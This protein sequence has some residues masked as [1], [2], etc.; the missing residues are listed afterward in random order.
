MVKKL[1]KKDKD[2]I[3]YDTD[4]IAKN[5]WLSLLRDF[6]TEEGPNFAKSAELA[7]MSGV[8]NFRD[9]E[10]PTIGLIT[11]ARFKRYKQLE[12][13]FK[14]YRFADD[15]YSDEELEFKTYQSFFDAQEHLAA[16]HP[17]SEIS[18]RVL[19]RARSIA[20][21]I[22]G[23]YDPEYTLTACRF[24]KKS[25]I[26][27]PLS[28]AY[29]DHKLT[30]AEAFTGSSECSRWFFESLLPGD[31]I[32]QEL[33][34]A[35]GVEPGS[36]ASLQHESLTLI[37]VP[38]SWKTY[39]PITPLTLLSLLYSYGVGE[40]VTARLRSIGLD[41][42]TLQHRHAK[43]VVKFSQTLSHATADLSN[44]SN[45]LLSWMLNRVL[46]REWYVAVKRTFQHQLAVKK[47]GC[48]ESVLHYTESVLPMGNGLTF[49]VET[50]VFYILLKA[51]AELSEVKGLISVYGDDLI[52]PSRLH[53]YVVAIF[54]QLKLT[55]NLEKTFVH[56]P[57]RESC[58]SDYYRGVDVR[59]AILP[60]KHQLLTRTCYSVWL[61]KV[62][63][64][65][66]R[67]WDPTEIESTLTLLLTELAS[68][69]LPL[70]RVP[71]SYPD[72]AGV[73]V[74]DPWVIPMD[75]RVLPWKPISIVFSNGSRAH[76]FY[77]LQVSST[78]RRVVS[79]LP[80]Y[81]LALQGLDDEPEPDNFWQTDFTYLRETPRKPLIWRT[82]K[83][84]R[85]TVTSNGKRK[86]V[87][88]KQQFAE[89]TSRRGIRLAPVL[90]GKTDLISDWI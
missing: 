29:I 40:Q 77:S 85:W 44:A 4:V 65:L 31:P 86:R 66:V 59:P 8:A 72:T 55:L 15:K 1:K 67:R 9:Y 57:F 45:S 43:L 5:I 18:H 78:T 30:D 25:S 80:Y 47:P 32:L 69:N 51:I 42:A 23:P 36:T 35:L 20:R 28:L 48:D 24:G 71:P 88:L 62:Y 13:F 81:W 2:V 27:C 64:L 34:S 14:K 74:E 68:L 21:S 16:Y 89:C 26:G 90:S 60:D 12:A 73:K 84:V 38:K 53:K 87:V 6:R 7:F 19:Q 3:K 61:Y 52:Y 54:P 37:N 41:I 17:V 10:F 56:S 11:P 39:R 76:F 83:R 58:G 75:A 63:N 49:P 70:Y 82:L 33:V 79:V 46:P 50:L 22:L